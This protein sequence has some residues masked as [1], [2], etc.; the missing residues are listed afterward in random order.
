MDIW[1]FATKCLSRLVKMM[2]W[3]TS[4]KEVRLGMLRST[5]NLRAMRD[6]FHLPDLGPIAR[7]LVVKPVKTIQAMPIRTL[8]P[9]SRS[10]FRISTDREIRP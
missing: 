10:S 6:H 3:N 4:S 2:L 7:Y 9:I 8:N 5:K 1:S